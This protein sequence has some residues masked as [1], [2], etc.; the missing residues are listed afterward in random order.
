METNN[1]IYM[2]MGYLYKECNPMAH[3]KN[4][5]T[6]RDYKEAETHLWILLTNNGKE[7]GFSKSFSCKTGVF[8]IKTIKL[9]YFY[10]DGRNLCVPD[11]LEN[12]I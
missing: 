5:I 8:W 1:I 11:P 3:V 6:T 7:T 12:N 9:D 2:V 10:E 4:F